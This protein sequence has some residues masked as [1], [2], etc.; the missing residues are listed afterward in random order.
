MP[1]WFW[2]VSFLGCGLVAVIVSN[3]LD[4]EVFDVDKCLFIIAGI[5][6]TVGGLAPLLEGEWYFIVYLKYNFILATVYLVR[7]ETLSWKSSIMF[8]AF[9]LLTPALVTLFIYDDYILAIILPD[10]FKTPI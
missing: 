3:N 5:L 6:S 4:L 10:R 7:E 9:M 2:L 1:S 8:L